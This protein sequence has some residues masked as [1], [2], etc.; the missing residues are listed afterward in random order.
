MT[1]IKHRIKFSVDGKPPKKTKRS[2]WSK[3]SNQTNSVIKLRQSAFE[4]C[5]KI[6]LNEP[7]QILFDLYESRKD[8][9][10]IFP[11]DHNNGFRE[12]IDWTV[13]HGIVADSHK[14]ILAKYYEYYFNNCSDSAKPLANK[15]KQYLENEELQKKFPEVYNGDFRFLLK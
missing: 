5:N 10:Q 15:I 8:L 13:T 6:R 11:N 2:L 4:A 7:L 12:I 3:K 14:E 9:Q 1:K